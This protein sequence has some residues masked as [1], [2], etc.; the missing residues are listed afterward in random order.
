MVAQEKHLKT[1][2]LLSL[3]L[4]YCFSTTC[5]IGCLSCATFGF[6]DPEC[7]LCDTKAGYYMKNGIC[8]K[9]DLNECLFLNFDGSCLGCGKNH[10]LDLMF[11]E[12]LLVPVS[13]QI[14]NCE[15]YENLSICTACKKGYYFHKEDFLCNPVLADKQIENCDFYGSES[16]CKKCKQNFWPAYDESECFPID[17]ANCLVANVMRCGQCS[18]NFFNNLNYSVKNLAQTFAQIE[19]A[20]YLVFEEMSYSNFTQQTCIHKFDDNCTEFLHSNACLTCADGYFLYEKDS[21]CYEKP[22]KSILK[23]KYY[24]T[25]LLC[26]ECEEGHH[27]ETG[28]LCVQ[29]EVVKNC[30]KYNPTAS[31]TKCLECEK[32]FYAASSDGLCKDRLESLKVNFCEELDLQNDI[33]IKCVFGYLIT[34][35]GLKCLRLISNCQEYKIS[36]KETKTL[37]C[38]VCNDGYY[39]DEASGLCAQPADHFSSKCQTYARNSMKC[40]RCIPDTFIASFSK[41]EQHDKDVI[42]PHCI[43]TSLIDRNTCKTCLPGFFLFPSDNNCVRLTKLIGN[44]KVYADEESCSEC[45]IGY[46]GTLC[47]AI[48]S[49][50]HCLVKDTASKKC[51][52]CENNYLMDSSLKV[53][54]KPSEILEDYCEEIN[55]ANKVFTC[56]VCKEN[57]LSMQYKDSSYCDKPEEDIP[58]SC[59][60]MGMRDSALKCVACEPGYYLKDNECVRQCNFA[61]YTIHLQR[62]SLTGETI[63]NYGERSCKL[64]I[65]DQCLIKTYAAVALTGALTEICAKCKVGASPVIDS[66]NYNLNH[67][68]EVEDSINAE[69]HP[70]NRIP[71]VTCVDNDALFS[72]VSAGTAK[73]YCKYFYTDDSNYTCQ[74]CDNGRS[75]LVVNT[76][77]SVGG[78]ATCTSSI[79]YCNTDYNFKGANYRAGGT[80]TLENLYSCSS[81]EGDRIPFIH[82]NR[83]SPGRY[84]LIPFNLMNNPPSTGAH[85]P[86]GMG[87]ECRNP[88][89]PS[90]F[91]LTSPLTTFTR[92]CGLG[93]MSVLTTRGELNYL[94]CLS[95]L[96]GFKATYDSTNADYVTQCDKIENCDTA[97]GLQWFNACSKCTGGFIYNYDKTKKTIIYDN[98]IPKTPHNHS[99]CVAGL[100]KDKCYIC[101]EGFTLNSDSICEVINSF[102]CTGQFTDNKHFMGSYNNKVDYYDFTT[103]LSYNFDGQGCRKCQTIGNVAIEVDSTPKYFCTP[104]NYIA[105]NQFPL[106]SSFVLNCLKYKGTSDSYKC[107]ECRENFLVDF[108]ELK[109]VSIVET[110]N[111]CKIASSTVSSECHT[112]KKG[113]F[114]IDKLCKDKSI[115]NCISKILDTTIKCET[116]QN[117]YYL[118]PVDSFC[119]PGLVKNCKDFGTSSEDCLTCFDGYQLFSDKFSDK[120]CI[121]MKGTNCHKWKASAVTAI[122][123]DCEVCVTG[124]GPNLNKNRLNFRPNMC[125]GPIE[126]PNCSVYQI[127]QN[128]PPA[129]SFKCEVCIEGFYQS[130]GLCMSRDF[131]DVH[132][133]TYDPTSDVCTVCQKS[134][135]LSADSHKCLSNPT[136]VN[137]CNLYEN[138]STC[139]TCIK[140]FYLMANVCIPVPTAKVQADCLQYINEV[141]CSLCSGS[142]YIDA[143]GSC[144]A[145][146]AE[147]CSTYSN[148]TECKSCIKGAIL[149]F[150]VDVDSV[151]KA[152]TQRK[153]CAIE[154]SVANCSIQSKYINTDNKYVYFCSQCIEGYY[155]SKEGCERVLTPIRN[156]LFYSGGTDCLYCIK[157]KVAT[158][159]R[160]TC[161]NVQTLLSNGFDLDPNCD[162]NRISKTPICSMCL[163]NYVSIEGK[164]EVCQIPDNCLTCDPNDKLK[165]IICKSE[166]YMDKDGLCHSGAAKDVVNHGKVIEADPGILANPEGARI[167]SFYGLCLVLGFMLVLSTRE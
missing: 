69:A 137:N 89:N 71:A 11:G 96:P 42:T 7:I 15:F 84:V 58:D 97:Y 18:N 6:G 85:T 19:M 51:T 145:S 140:D 109:C 119:Y 141:K 102:D 23:C 164:C 88:N 160:Q 133:L 28:I 72:K 163:P 156:C 144:Q 56:A 108:T 135:V 17:G 32:N 75:G 166:N 98:C 38:Y 86:N 116:C 123:F 154:P 99:N 111:N 36:N 130:S 50:E 121:Q 48:P 161:L 30:I 115:P 27:L 43:Q 138:L 10:Y 62:L 4:T 60:K 78:I 101:E 118:K 83:K 114:K 68:L 54:V 92:S 70:M 82:G 55:L 65:G 162:T 22:L 79:N 66:V 136:G 125:L 24:K 157:G 63:T 139:K 41:C 53:C 165:C 127:L 132:C 151:T 2:V 20:K 29:D 158:Q 110:L 34:T 105:F 122:K 40:E 148:K 149:G 112:C 159:D 26:Q 16:T 1:L 155:L 44:C 76:T 46:W 73:E 77:L 9:S 37:L 35:D 49:F 104:R 13:N 3:L 126:L 100:V 59:I 124:F 81:C 167:A 45:L 146:T 153:V 120:Y 113:F 5:T 150:V 67:L 33:C 64:S 47:E 94:K 25:L 80:S 103:A 87:T 131:L 152:E 91:N 61:N 107:I 21:K 134:Y 142:N 14:K 129:S 128:S 57:C 117:G 31:S 39:L 147:N 95:C 12:C 52:Q 106:G 74:R 143:L 90:D 8:S 93:F